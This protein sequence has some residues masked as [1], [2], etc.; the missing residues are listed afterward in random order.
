M[1]YTRAFIAFLLLLL[2]FRAQAQEKL[3][4]K[5]HIG[6]Q[7][8]FARYDRS[9][10]KAST[11]K[12]KYFDITDNLGVTLQLKLSEIW[13]LETGWSK[14]NIGW[15]YQI[16]I[17]EHLLNDPYPRPVRKHSLSNYIHR[18]PLQ[19]LYTFRDITYFPLNRERNLYLF[20]FR[21]HAI[22]GTS[23]D[24]I[25]YKS[26][27]DSG[28]M[29]LGTSVPSSNSIDLAEEVT[30]RSRWGASVRVGIG[31][32]YLHNG[33]ERLEL[34]LYYSRGLRDMVQADVDYSMNSES[35]T[36]RM[37]ARGSLIG[38]TLAYPIRLKT[39]GSEQPL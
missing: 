9:I 7:V 11:F 35:R 26:T 39:F 19:A 10:G 14:G 24:Y 13:G 18:F 1:Y 22:A 33:K 23:L 15:G 8:P 27:F 38:L 5:P 20:N 4:I 6:A 34:N 28:V 16:S 32:Q 29:E 25:D 37:L 31:M 21:L 12:P 17:P 30:I 2:A 36:T 3:F